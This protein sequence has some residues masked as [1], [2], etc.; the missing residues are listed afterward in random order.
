[1]TIQTE[2]ARYSNGAQFRRADLHVHSFGDVGS[3][4]VTDLSMTPE[5]IV[6]MGFEAARN[7]SGNSVSL[8]LRRFEGKELTSR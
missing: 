4:D 3:Y 5:G 6:D 1:M 2:I 7:H 8:I